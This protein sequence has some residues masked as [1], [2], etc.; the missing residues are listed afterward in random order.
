MFNVYKIKDESRIIPL[1]KRKAPGRPKKIHTAY[2][3][4]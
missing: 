1:G 4:D 2:Y 3:H